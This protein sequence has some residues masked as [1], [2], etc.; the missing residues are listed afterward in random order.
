VK[1]HIGGTLL[2][3]VHS[4]GDQKEQVCKLFKGGNG[5]GMSLWEEHGNE[6]VGVAW[7]RGFGNYKEI[8]G[9]IKAI[10]ATWV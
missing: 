4:L 7:E 2:E 3:A 6:P 9:R 1:I 10:G 5:M 8:N